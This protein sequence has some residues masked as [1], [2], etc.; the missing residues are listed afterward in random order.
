ML[1]VSQPPESAL[2]KEIESFCET[3]RMTVTSFG[4][5]SIND[6]NLVSDLRKGR[7]LRRRTRAKVDEFMST[8]RTIVNA[9]AQK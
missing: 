1:D 5:D 4:E 3:H 9:K 2:L 8:T 7:E 6:R